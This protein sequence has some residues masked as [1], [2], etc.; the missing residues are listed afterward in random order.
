MR[1][2]A[3]CSPPTLPPPSGTT[4]VVAATPNWLAVRLSRRDQPSRFASLRATM[5]LRRS[6]TNDGFLTARGATA[7][8]GADSKTDRATA[9]ATLRNVTCGLASP[10]GTKEG[11]TSNLATTRAASPTS[12][13]KRSAKVEN[14]KT[15]TEGDLRLLDTDLLVFPLSSSASTPVRPLS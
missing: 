8:N 15:L 12:V 13:V 11:L 7:L 5:A 6:A 4:R 10:P 2:D 14:A 9:P 1:V 3:C